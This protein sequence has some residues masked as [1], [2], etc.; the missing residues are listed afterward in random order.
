MNN[1]VV[2]KTPVRLLGRLIE[3]DID[4]EGLLMQPDYECESCVLGDRCEFFYVN[5]IW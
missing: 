5:I 2:P 1:H 3:L 4:S